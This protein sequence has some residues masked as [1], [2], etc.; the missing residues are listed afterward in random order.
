MTKPP[1]F[2]KEILAVL[3]L[4]LKISVPL[5]LWIFL[6]STGDL[7]ITKTTVNPALLQP[8]VDEGP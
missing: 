2:S 1:T 8:N 5:I 4:M 3:W 7:L 6:C